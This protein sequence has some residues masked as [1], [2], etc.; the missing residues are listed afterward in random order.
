MKNEK[1]SAGDSSNEKKGYNEKNPGQPE[2]AFPPDSLT[3]SAK[4]NVKSNTADKKK[5]EDEN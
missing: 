2:A 1:L 5:K 4:K 3:V